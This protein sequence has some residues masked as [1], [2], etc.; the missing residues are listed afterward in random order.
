MTSLLFI[1]PADLGETVLATG[2]LAQAMAPLHRPKVTV[3]CEPSALNLFTALPGLDGLYERKSGVGEWAALNWHVGQRQ[4][5]LAIDFGT[6]PLFARAARRAR[7]RAGA[8]LQHLSQTYAEAIGAERPLAPKLWLND[9]ARAAAAEAMPGS[10]PLLVLAPGGVTA[11]KRWSPEHFAAVARRLAG[12]P[13]KG[14][15]VA[16]LGAAARDAEV[17]R[18]V[19]ASL[20][21]D[22]IGARD[23]GRKLDL[24][25]AAALLTEATLCIGNDNALTHISAAVGAPTLTLFGPTDERVRAPFGQRTR[26][27]RGR[28]YEEI[29]GSARTGLDDASLMADISVDAVEAAAVALLHAGGLR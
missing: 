11:G 9:G 19:A 18:V 12:G 24:L 23:L 17:T 20:D 10:G 14:A 4:F 1:A 5:D 25:G 28:A 22:G 21:A 3:V 6:D 13:L 7:P 29:M 27:L 15:R 16:I 26:A 8:A 2:A